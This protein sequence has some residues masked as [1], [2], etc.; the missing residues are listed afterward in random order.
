MKLELLA[1]DTTAIVSFLIGGKALMVF[2]NLKIHS[3]VTTQFN[4]QEVHHLLPKLANQYH[5]PFSIVLS[6]MNKWA[7]IK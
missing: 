7:K 6:V 3:L 1:V 2:D 4:L 5:Y